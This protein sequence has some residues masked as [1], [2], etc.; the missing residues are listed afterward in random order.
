M[1]AYLNFYLPYA[2]GTLMF[3]IGG[4]PFGPWS[5]PYPLLITGPD[6]TSSNYAAFGHPEYAERDGMV[7]YISYYQ[8]STGALRLVKIAFLS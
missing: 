8:A 3:Q 1:R 2:S 5:S 6:G 7:Q 4:S